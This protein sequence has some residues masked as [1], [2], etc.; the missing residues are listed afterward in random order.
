MSSVND[1]RVA[2]FCKMVAVVLV[3]LINCDGEKCLAYDLASAIIS[4]PVRTIDEAENINM[5]V[6]AM[7]KLIDFDPP[8]P[9]PS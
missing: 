5:I 1:S 9:A 2:I 4:P 8:Y 7:T 6:R 3:K